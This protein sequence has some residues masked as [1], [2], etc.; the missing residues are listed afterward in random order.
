MRHGK[1]LEEEDTLI[2]R[3]YVSELVGEVVGQLKIQL[4]EEDDSCLVTASKV[5]SI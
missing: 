1:R 4:A 5:S 3:S 2:T